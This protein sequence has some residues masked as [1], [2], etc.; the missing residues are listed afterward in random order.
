MNLR[1]RLLVSLFL[2]A[3]AASCSP[4]PETGPDAAQALIDMSAE[5]M[6][7]WAAM[8][9]IRTQE[10]LTGGGDW[11]PMQAIEPGGEPRQLNTFGQT[12][13]VDFDS[14]RMKLTFDA[15]RTYPAPA[16]VKFTEV[17]DNEVGMLQTTDA[18][19]ATVSE[20]LHPSRYATR[21][22]DLNRLPLRVLYVAKNAPGLTRSEDVNVDSKTYQVLKYTDS[23]LPV[24][25][26]I[27]SFNMLPARVVY[28]EDDPIMGD[29]LNEAAFSDWRESDG[30][31]LPYTVSTFLN[32]NKIREERVRTL[33]NNS[34]FDSGAFD[35]PADI[36]A[37]PEVGERVVSQ[38]TL[39]RAVMG[40]GYADFAREQKVDLVQLSPGVL[41][42]TG[43]THHSMAVEMAD[44]II[45]VE[46]PLFEE[47][48]LA[49][50]KAIEERFPGKPIR[51]LVVT[52]F[53]FDH[54]GG[55]RAFAAKGATILAHEAIVPFL[56]EV[57]ARPKTVKPDSL[58]NAGAVTP[59]VEGV[60][61]SRSLMDA[62]RTLELREAPNPHV[63]GM[64]MAYLPAER[65]LFESD[66]YTPGAV[67][68]P[69]DQN[70]TALYLA[71][72]GANWAVDRVVGGHGGVGP[73][74]D[75]ARAASPPAA[76]PAS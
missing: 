51:Y 72:T 1:S 70:A 3:C 45:V 34:R 6:G 48:S 2:L 42:V 56:K 43:S 28:T 37:Q 39:R 30:V 4:A 36:R 46:A 12:L 38:W 75:L 13:L 16:P 66:L 62:A 9:A 49:V 24:E 32:G 55:V 53:H 35:I 44:H 26:H 14:G 8:D 61:Q 54:S 5:S 64:L 47:R 69:G 27:D 59:V 68:Q 15:L 58:A 11:E 19:G 21:L 40:V 18:A 31:R 74:R 20:R 29:T 23:G 41:H 73:F 63:V 33:I 25:L 57:L 22:R 7:G 10:I 60:A 52:H 71:I 50:I 65:L 76:I 17:I 67:V